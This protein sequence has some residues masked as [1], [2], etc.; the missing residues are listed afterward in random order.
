MFFKFKKYKQGFNT[1]D[2][3]VLNDSKKTRLSAI[4]KL[5]RRHTVRL[6]ENSLTEE[7]G[8]VCR[9]AKTLDGEKA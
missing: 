2:H 7:G 3:R 4:S 5:D 9:G 6:K 1:Q 8:G